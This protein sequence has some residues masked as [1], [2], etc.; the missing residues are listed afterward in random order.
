MIEVILNDRL[1]KKVRGDEG[2]RC[3]AGRAFAAPPPGCAAHAAAAA[4]QALRRS[5]IRSRAQAHSS[6]YMHS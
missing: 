2:C 1:G 3:T 4:N 6:A 5:C